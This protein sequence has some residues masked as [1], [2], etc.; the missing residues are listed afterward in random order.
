MRRALISSV[1]SLAVLGL[2]A[3]APARAD[4]LATNLVAGTPQDA[5]G[6]T[7]NQISAD[8]I[9]MT[10][11]ARFAGGGSETVLWSD[12]PGVLPPGAYGTGWSVTMLPNINTGLTPWNVTNFAEDCPPMISLLFDAGTANSVFDLTD[13]NPGSPGSNPGVTFQ[14]LNRTTAAGDGNNV[15]TVVSYLDIVGLNGNPPV[16]DLYRQLLIEFPGGFTS[17]L[18]PLSSIRPLQFQVDTDG[19]QRIGPVVPEPTSLALFG[20]AA[21]AYGYSRRRKADSFTRSQ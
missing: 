14:Q 6:I 17:N 21:A 13:P 10:V 19:V 11:T 15:D 20:L 16:G 1:L 12:P 4:V 7:F 2:A 3:S 5:A 18:N 9:G 8:L